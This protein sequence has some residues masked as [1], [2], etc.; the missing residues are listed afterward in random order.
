MDLASAR[1]VRDE[2]AAELVMERSSADIG[3]F[4][5]RF[6]GAATEAPLVAGLSRPHELVGIAAHTFAATL[7][8]APESV[9]YGIAVTDRPGDYR[10][11]VRA[12]SRSALSR[13]AIAE[14]RRRAGGEAD[15]RYI[16]P[17]VGFGGRPWYRSQCRPLAIGSSVAPTGRAPG[18]VGGFVDRVGSGTRLLSANHVLTAGG[19]SGTGILQPAKKDGG[20]SARDIIGKLDFAVPITEDGPNDVDCALVELDP[21]VDFDPTR[22]GAALALQGVAEGF[23]MDREPVQKVGRTTGLT[24]GVLAAFEVLDVDIRLP[25]GWRT[26]ESLIEIHGVGP[27][28]FS[29]PGDSGSLVFTSRERTARG[30]VV[31]GTAIGGSNGKGIT[32]ATS[33]PRILERLEAALVT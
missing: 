10:V 29:S 14:I 25:V 13:N 31:A 22:L 17:V 12:R 6:A 3:E 19:G 20:K 23:P 7:R 1:G 33:M 21:A 24:Q 28:A 9:A 2:L 30:L 11:A 18:T 27:H 15:I 8:H 5:Q 16:G 32:Y 4:F 26:F